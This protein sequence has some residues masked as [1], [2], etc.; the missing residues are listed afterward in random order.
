[1]KF[2]QIVTIKGNDEFTEWEGFDL[3]TALEEKAKA[4]NAF[5]CLT[6]YDKKNSTLECRVYNLPDNTDISDRDALIDAIVE[7]AGYNNF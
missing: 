4:L 7:S 3:E 5:E 2:Y 6:A 1:M